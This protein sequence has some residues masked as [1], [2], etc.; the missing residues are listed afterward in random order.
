MRAILKQLLGVDAIDV[1]HEW[2]PDVV[3]EQLLQPLGQACGLG[4][5]NREHVRL[6]GPKPRRCVVQ[7][8]ARSG[9][10]GEIGTAPVP[11]A[12]EVEERRAGPK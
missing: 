9:A 12:T 7:D 10:V 8:D 3:S 4:G 5:G 2:R 11:Q 1:A 6:N